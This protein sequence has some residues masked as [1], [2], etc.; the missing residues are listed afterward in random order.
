MLQSQVGYGYPTYF[1]PSSVAAYGTAPPHP[2]PSKIARFGAPGPVT[3]SVTSNTHQTT[4]MT[5]QT[6]PKKQ[7]R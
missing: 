1:I 6:P 2:T 4:T 5:A 3:P 7:K